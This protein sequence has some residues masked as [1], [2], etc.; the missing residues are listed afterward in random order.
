KVVYDQVPKAGATVNRGAKIIMYLDPEAKY[1]SNSTKVVVPE[2][3][4]LTN[5][6][7]EQILTE[8][9]LKLQAEGVGTIIRQIPAPGTIVDYG[10]A[11]RVEMKPLEQKQ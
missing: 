11:I 2:L 5:D 10:S 4:G 3:K 7:G 6:K 9:G 1:F 8:L